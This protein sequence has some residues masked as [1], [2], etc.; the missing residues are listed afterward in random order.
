[1]KVAF[2]RVHVAGN[3]MRIASFTKRDHVQ[4]KQLGDFF[5][6]KIA[7]RPKLGVIPDVPLPQLVMVDI[8]KP[9]KLLSKEQTHI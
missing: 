3:L 2:V 1:M 5:E 8:L 9:N 4:L 7:I 6:K